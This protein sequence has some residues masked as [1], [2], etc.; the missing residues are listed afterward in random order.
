VH[1]SEDSKDTKKPSHGGLFVNSRSAA[2]ERSSSFSSDNDRALSDGG[3]A[4]ANPK[5]GTY[6]GKYAFPM[7]IWHPQ[8]NPLAKGFFV[9]LRSVTS[10]GISNGGF[11]DANPK[12]GTYI[13]E[14]LL[15]RCGRTNNRANR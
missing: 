9:N 14:A 12:A 8:K 2:T 10:E 15:R 11:A 13:G 6:L 1:G 7:T 3:F 4:G 5:A